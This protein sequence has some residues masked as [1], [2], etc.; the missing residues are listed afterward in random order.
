MGVIRWHRLRSSATCR[1]TEGV[2][3]I[4]RGIMTE[5]IRKGVSLISLLS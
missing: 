3:A 2:G 4:E 1:D 5:V